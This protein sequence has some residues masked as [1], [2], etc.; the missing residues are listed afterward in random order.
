METQSII[1]PHMGYVGS[2]NNDA[3]LGALAASSLNNK[4]PYTATGDN[5]LGGGGLM[6]G[7]LL[8]SLLGRRGGGLFGG[9]DA[10]G[11]NILADI[12]K[13]VGDA[14]T[15][16]S[17]V[18]SR[19]QSAIQVQDTNNQVNFRALDN[20]ICETEKSAIIY[21]KDGQ[22]ENLRTEARLTD[23][24]TAFERNADTQFCD[25]KH[26]IEGVNTNIERV[27]THLTHIIDSKFC[28]L[29]T[30]LL[31]QTQVILGQ[32]NAD[33]LDSKNDEIAQ[34]RERNRHFEQVLAFSN[35]LTAINSSLSDLSQQQKL[36]NQ[37][38]NFG[39]GAIGAQSATNNQVR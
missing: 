21:A 24:I 14:A 31:K 37:S 13:D 33:K 10:S 8:A 23:R 28:H 26:N 20:K 4:V 39:T 19:I 9:D 7:L 17:R 11:G 25:V 1:P 22:I 15:E 18:E 12:R 27:N 16:A 6:G 36:T 5:L 32:L 30:E 38:I 2:N 3:I 35:Q 29:G 34:L